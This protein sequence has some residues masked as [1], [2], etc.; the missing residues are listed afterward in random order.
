VCLVQMTGAAPIRVL[1]HCLAM[2]LRQSRPALLVLGLLAVAGCSSGSTTS[3]P[4]P[5]TP[6]EVDLSDTPTDTPTDSTDAAATACFARPR[7]QGDI[8][9][10]EK[11]P[12][13][14]YYASQLGG[15][16]AFNHRSNQCQNSVEFNLDAVPDQPGSCA[17]IASAS[18]NPGYN[19][20]DR[21][22]PPLKK[23]F[24]SKGSC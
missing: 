21:P 4:S 14:P 5:A 16:F 7:T 15:G 23:V 12:T 6:T 18:D 10:R 19:P 9:V 20:D 17:Q 1:R 22:A 3:D 11:D 13:L 8:I 2:P 24:A